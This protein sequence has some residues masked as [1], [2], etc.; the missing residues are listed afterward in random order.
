MI[1]SSN[2]VRRGHLVRKIV[3]EAIQ[4]ILRLDLIASSIRDR[5]GVGGVLT[6]DLVNLPSQ[7]VVYV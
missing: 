1:A 5:G 4:W 6:L 3:D 7:T 2:I